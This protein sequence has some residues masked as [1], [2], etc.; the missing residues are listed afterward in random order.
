M[1]GDVSVPKT[2]NDLQDWFGTIITRPIDQNSYMQALSPHGIPMQQEASR[3]IRPSPTMSPDQRIQIYNQQYWWRLLNIMHENFPLVVRL[4][5]YFDFNKTLAEPYLNT[6]PPNHWSLTVLGD[7]LV[8]WIEKNYQGKDALF[9]LNSAQL[10]WAFNFGFT[11]KEYE[12][13]DFVKATR[14]ENALLTLNVSLQPH[15]TLFEAK[16]DLLP[17]RDKMLEKEPEY[18][19][20]NDFPKLRKGGKFYTAIYRSKEG[21]MLYKNLSKSEFTLLKQFEGG[22]SIEKACFWLEEQGNPFL[23]EAMKHLSQWFHEWTILGWL[24][25]TP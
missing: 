22:N 19:E 2:L 16:A 13:L 23:E 12:P 6:F 1:K 21:A 25:K 18:W 11:A 24:G 14:E 15:L 10:D 5:G 8:S 9:V 17:F 3:W 20:E 7:K 4:F